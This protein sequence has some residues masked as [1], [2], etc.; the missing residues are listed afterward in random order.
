MLL[1]VQEMPALQMDRQVVVEQVLP[2][3]IAVIAVGR[4]KVVV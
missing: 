3:V 2:A 1:L 4:E